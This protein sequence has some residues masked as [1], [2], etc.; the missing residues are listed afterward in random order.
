[1]LVKGAFLAYTWARENAYPECPFQAMNKHKTRKTPLREDQVSRQIHWL[2]G[3]GDSHPHRHEV[4]GQSREDWLPARGFHASL[5][6]CLWEQ[7]KTDLKKT[8]KARFSMK[9]L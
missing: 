2:K 8:N 3:A 5:T 6:S 1:M 9:R 4:K 7:Q